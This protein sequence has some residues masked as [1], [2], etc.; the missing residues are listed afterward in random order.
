MNKIVLGNSVPVST[1]TP[2]VKT[3]KRRNAGPFSERQ[4]EP[5]LIHFIGGEAWLLY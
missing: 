1:E 4:K 2:P 3:F 5:G